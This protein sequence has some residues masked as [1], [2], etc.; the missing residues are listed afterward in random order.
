[1]KNSP[2][3]QVVW[4]AK[5]SVLLKQ[6]LLKLWKIHGL[7]IAKRKPHQRVSPIQISHWFIPSSKMI[8]VFSVAWWLL[9]LTNHCQVMGAYKN[10]LL[11]ESYQIAF[12]TCTSSSFVFLKLDGC[13]KCKAT[14]IL[15]MP[16]LTSDHRIKDMYR[17]TYMAL[18]LIDG[19]LP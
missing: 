18:F 15:L 16:A 7:P 5:I 14:F 3:L 13:V 9:G 8:S 12:L 1:M 10:Q 6:D 19:K 2:F 4:N 17:K 11:K